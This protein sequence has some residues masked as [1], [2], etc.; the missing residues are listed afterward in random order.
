MFAN[1][2][3]S[4]P[5]LGSCW[6]NLVTNRWRLSSAPEF[7]VKV[8]LQS[9]ADDA[10]SSVLLMFA[11]QD[12]PQCFLQLLR[13]RRLRLS[14]DA[15][16]HCLGI[17]PRIYTTQGSNKSCALACN[18]YANIFVAQKNSFHTKLTSRCVVHVALLQKLNVQ[19]LSR[20]TF[21][22]NLV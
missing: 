11:R 17:L 20:R 21:L 7:Q 6:R 22:R 5:S 16:L 19:P 14:L 13:R 18:M 10:Q 15:F 1:L 4:R 12:C 3:C 2:C 8:L 9:K